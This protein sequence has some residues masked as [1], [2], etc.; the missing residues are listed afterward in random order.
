M[1]GGRRDTFV[2]LEGGEGIHRDEM[3]GADVVLRRHGDGTFTLLK[4]RW[5]PEVVRQPWDGLPSRVKRL[6]KP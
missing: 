6:V 4:H 1:G 5:G 3:A 2:L